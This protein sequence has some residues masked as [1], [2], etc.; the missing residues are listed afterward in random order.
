VL[1]L[2]LA[3]NF[4]LSFLN[5]KE[6]FSII[7]FFLLSLIVFKNYSLILEKLKI[8]ISIYAFLSNIIF[9]L[10]LPLIDFSLPSG[11]E[12]EI[13]S[14]CNLFPTK[15]HLLNL[16]FS[17]PSHFAMISGPV[18]LYLIHNMANFRYYEKINS[19]FFV[20]CSFLFFMSAT[21]VFS[22]ICS[23]IFFL[24][25]LL[26]EK[27]FFFFYRNLLI[28]LVF[29]ICLFLNVKQCS[30]RV[31]LIKKV[32]SKLYETNE[33]Q[34]KIENNS[35]LIFDN[36]RSKIRDSSGNS[37][38]LLSEFQNF[39]LDLNR[40]VKLYNLICNKEDN[41][42]YNKEILLRKLDNYYQETRNTPV[43]TEVF[44]NSLNVAFYT[45]KNKIIG[46]G[47]QK[48]ETGFYAFLK[49]KKLVPENEGS[50]YLNY[51]DGSSNFSK[52]L[53]EFGWLSIF[54]V[55][56]IFYFMLISNVSLSIK[57]FL[58]SVIITQ[59]IRGAGYFNGGFLF[60]ALIIFSS[61]FFNQKKL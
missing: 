44:K 6:F 60:F 35:N 22:Q 55:L 51:N 50:V 45:L 19:L 16:F 20:A 24:L 14:S 53:T 59:C 4:N 33:Y 29:I 38:K 2:V 39:C 28:Y 54:F 3:V 1:Q 61:L 49:T 23:I 15:N 17:E 56:I 47:F 34:G 13:F 30:Y 11:L 36:F 8:T 42:Y 31:F 37:N 58:I 25:F 43:T 5:R 48:Y 18:S 32:D 46:Y 57:L 41:F 21:L 9:I 10:S 7:L 26:R 40:Q 27:K 52:I 12:K